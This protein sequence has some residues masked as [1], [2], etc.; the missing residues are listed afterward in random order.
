MTFCVKINYCIKHTTFLLQNVGAKTHFNIDATTKER[1]T[2]KKITFILF[3]FILLSFA[4][5]AGSP[6]Q[7]VPI[8]VG[9]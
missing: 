5:R 2:Q 6:Q 7:H 8:I 1:Q 3:Y 4:T 9:P